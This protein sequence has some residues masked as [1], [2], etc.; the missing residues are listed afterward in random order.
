MFCTIVFGHFD[1]DLDFVVQGV[2]LFDGQ[3]GEGPRFPRVP[4]GLPR[5]VF[6]DFREFVGIGRI[7]SLSMKSLFFFCEL[8]IK[9][10]ISG[11]FHRF[12]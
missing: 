10:V 6:Q 7:L 3:R 2:I 9:Y 11:R 1:D 5:F 8:M 12:Q 4:P